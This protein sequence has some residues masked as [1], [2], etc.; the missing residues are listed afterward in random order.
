MSVLSLYHLLQWL[1]TDLRGGL[2]LYE[3]LCF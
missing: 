2:W 3:L 1:E